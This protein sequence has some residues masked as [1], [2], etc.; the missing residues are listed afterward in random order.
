ML[1]ESSFANRKADYVW[2][3]FLSS[4]MLLV[5]IRFSLLIRQLL[6]LTDVALARVSSFQPSLPVLVPRFRT[7]I[8]LVTEAPV[9]SDISVRPHYYHRTVPPL[10]SCCLLLGAERIMGRRCGRSSGVCCGAYWLVYEGCV[11]ARDGGW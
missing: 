8:L 1:E 9:Y 2:L 11:D 10:C 7:N 5:S 3:L 4:V 6:D